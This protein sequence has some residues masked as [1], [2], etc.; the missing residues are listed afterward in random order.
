MAPPFRLPRASPNL[1]GPGLQRAAL[2]SYRR[3]KL[4]TATSEFQHPLLLPSLQ[5]P[6]AQ[7]AIPPMPEPMRRPPE[8]QKPVFR[9]PRLIQVPHVQSRQY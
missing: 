5:F 7:L 2:V 6:M 9:V 3:P 4:V 1:A 8:L